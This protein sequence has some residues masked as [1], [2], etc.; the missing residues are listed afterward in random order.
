M[1]AQ[2]PQE[3]LEQHT[4]AGDPRHWDI[5]FRD[6]QAVW[7]KCG[8]KQDVTARQAGPSECS[9]PHSG[10]CRACSRP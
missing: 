3:G 6:R 7:Q 2:A 1:Q 5:G 9:T 4:A 10:K 8:V